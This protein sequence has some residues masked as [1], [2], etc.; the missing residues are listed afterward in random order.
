VDLES[1]Q[2]V[3]HELQEKPRLVRDAAKSL[4]SACTILRQGA[5]NGVHSIEK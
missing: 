4:R 5:V 2:I 3:R 1:V